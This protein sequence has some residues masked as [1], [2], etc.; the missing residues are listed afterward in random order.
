[1][2]APTASI[3]GQVLDPHCGQT[4]VVTTTGGA[5]YAPQ[6]DPGLVIHNG[7]A[8][9][10]RVTVPMPPLVAAAAARFPGLVPSHFVDMGSGIATGGVIHEPNLLPRMLLP[11]TCTV[12]LVALPHLALGSQPPHRPATHR[13][14][15]YSPPWSA[16][17]SSSV[18][19]HSAFQ[20]AAMPAVVQPPGCGQLT[21]QVLTARDRAFLDRLQRRAAAA[22]PLSINVDLCNDLCLDQT[23]RDGL[24]RPLQLSHCWRGRD[25]RGYSPD[26]AITCFSWPFGHKCDHSHFFRFSPFF[27]VF[28]KVSFFAKFISIYD[29]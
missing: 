2:H 29:L 5:Y 28:T 15:D 9:V 19:L 26:L 7:Q 8:S 16:R 1:M 20:P 3:A 12:S 11:A 21:V 17:A 27:Q 10:P 14:T 6:L 22:C 4:K 25:V 18:G 13:R 24:F 23:I